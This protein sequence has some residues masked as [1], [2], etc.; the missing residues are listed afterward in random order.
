MNLL[1]TGGTGFFGRSLIRYLESERIS[2]GYLPY[3]HITILSRDPARFHTKYPQLASLSWINWQAGDVLVADSLPTDRQYEFVLHAAGDSTDDAGL[4][5]LQLY[6][7]IVT[8]TEIMLQFAARSGTKRFLLTSSGGA[9]G[10]QPADMEEIP[11]TY[12]GIPN[13]LALGSVY[14]IAKRQAELLCFLYGQQYGIETVIA[15][16]FA[17][18]GEDLPTNAHF[19]IG[20]FIRD[21]LNADAI[22]VQ[23]DGTPLRSYMDQRDL[24]KWLFYLLSNARPN[25]AYNVGSAVAISIRDLA[26]LVR[27]LL[28]PFKP[29]RVLGMEMQTLQRNRYIPSI[30]KAKDQLQLDLTISLDVAISFAANAYLNRGFTQVA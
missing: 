13:P 4:T 2:H 18:V 19:A 1:I 9:Y 29:V 26:Y 6:Q 23:G 14:G 10:P 20:N 16:C 30:N 5:A 25:Q 3:A 24:A 21:A 11:E 7:Q 8:G 28:A 12:N 17:F 27:D 22:T 15:R